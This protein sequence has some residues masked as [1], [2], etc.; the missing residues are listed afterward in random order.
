MGAGHSEFKIRE[1]NS[2]KFRLSSIKKEQPEPLKKG[3]KK[4][5]NFSKFINQNHSRWLVEGETK[6]K[7]I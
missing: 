6:N 1:Y 2:L 4:K 3:V 5:R 7:V